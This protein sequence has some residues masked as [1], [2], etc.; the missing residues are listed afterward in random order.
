MPW[1]GSQVDLRVPRRQQNGERGQNWPVLPLAVTGV[2]SLALG[3]VLAGANYT[4][5][6]LTGV[7][8]TSPS[9]G[10][11][12]QQCGFTPW[13]LGLPSEDV[14]IPADDG[15]PLRGWLLPRP[16]SR[17]VVVALTGYRARRSDLLGIAAALWRADYQ[18]LLFDYRGHGESPGRRVTLGY[19]EASD[20]RAALGWLSWWQRATPTCA[21]W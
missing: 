15:T 17:R 7:P 10:V 2:A 6:T 16:T 9:T 13:E 5:Q 18:V 21:P 1:E 3:A 8:S 4:I 11:L 20:V 14:T 19:D 12:P